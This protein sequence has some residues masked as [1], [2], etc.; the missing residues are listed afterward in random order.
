MYIAH[1][2]KASFFE[3]QPFERDDSEEDSVVIG[4]ISDGGP[5]WF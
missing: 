2:E 1:L 4:M 3:K 5:K